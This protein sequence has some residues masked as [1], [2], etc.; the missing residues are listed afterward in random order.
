MFQNKLGVGSHMYVDHFKR[1]N[2]SIFVIQSIATTLPKHI[3][4]KCVSPG[5]A[6]IGPFLKTKPNQ[7]V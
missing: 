7:T 1:F 6:K 2:P 5:T 4:A 3:L